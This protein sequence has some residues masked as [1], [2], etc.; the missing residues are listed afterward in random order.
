MH[1]SWG[2]TKGFDF[3]ADHALVIPIESSSFIAEISDISI[4]VL[5]A[6]DSGARLILPLGKRY[7][8]DVAVDG[9]VN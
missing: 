2:I 5:C 4:T 7:P 1:C 8:T 9:R 3:L 6:R